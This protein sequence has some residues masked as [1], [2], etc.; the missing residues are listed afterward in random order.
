[1]EHLAHHDRQRYGRDPDI[2]YLR[3]VRNMARQHYFGDALPLFNA[4]FGPC[5]LSA[6]LGAEVEIYPDTV[7]FKPCTHDLVTLTDI[8]FDP[9]NFWWKLVE[10]FVRRAVNEGRLVVVPELGG[11]GDNLA[12]L[13]GIDRLLIDMVEQPKLVKEV[14]RLMLTIMKECYRRL[15][16]IIETAGRGTASWLGIWSPQR[17]GIIQNDMSIMISTDIYGEFFFDEFNEMLQLVDHSLFHLDGTRSQKHLD[18]LLDFPRLGGIQVG[19]DMGTPAMAVL[20]VLKRIQHRD[21]R[22]IVYVVPDEVEDL[23]SNISPQ[24]VCVVASVKNA[25]EA[26]AY[27]RSL[28]KACRH[29]PRRKMGC[30]IKETEK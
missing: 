4:P 21:K 16:T 6:F 12:A 27:L 30:K 9:G 1:M 29:S 23:F 14:L 19:S 26:E 11:L 8:K 2:I 28:E 18:F 22:M 24:G 20:P 3:A 15:Y 17:T 7:W 25:E 10:G 13:Y 5:M